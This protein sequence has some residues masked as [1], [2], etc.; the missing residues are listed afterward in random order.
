MFAKSW[1]DLPPDT[2]EEDTAKSTKKLIVVIVVVV[3]LLVLSVILLW[4]GCSRRKQSGDVT[5]GGASEK[6]LPPETSSPM[7]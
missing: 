5:C 1:K 6:S 2:A 3:T 7:K 4:C